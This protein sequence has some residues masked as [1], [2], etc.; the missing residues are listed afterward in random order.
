MD[1]AVGQR[2][3]ADGVVVLVAV[4]VV[5]IA[6]EGLAQSVRVVE[7]RGNAVEAE[8]VELEL[9]EPVFT[10]R[11][12]EVQHVVLAVV[13]AQRIPGGMLVAVAGIEELVGVASQV[14]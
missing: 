13:E 12:Q 5:A 11:K 14:A 1:Q 9:L 8:A 7:H 6:A 10:V 2:Q 4:E 3:V